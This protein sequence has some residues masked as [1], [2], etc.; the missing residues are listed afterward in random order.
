VQARERELG[1]GGGEGG[2]LAR[3]VDMVKADLDGGD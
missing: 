3:D 1:L 2:E